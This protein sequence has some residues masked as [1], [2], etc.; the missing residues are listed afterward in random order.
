VGSVKGPT[1]QVGGVEVHQPLL[2][3]VV[4]SSLQR[5]VEAAEEGVAITG[6]TPAQQ[7]LPV[8]VEGLEQ[9][10]DGVLLQSTNRS[11][12]DIGFFQ[13]QLCFEGTDPLRG[14]L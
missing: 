5:A 6:L 9:H 13:R 7:V 1:G 14:L 4:A 10:T 12:R 8:D 11:V 3:R 2:L